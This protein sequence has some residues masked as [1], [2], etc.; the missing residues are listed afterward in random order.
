MPHHA[1]LVTFLVPRFARLYDSETLLCFA[2]QGLFTIFGL[3]G[4][5]FDPLRI[6]ISKK[7]L[8]KIV[9]IGPKYCKNA[10]KNFAKIFWTPV[11]PPYFR[12]LWVNR[13]SK[14][15]SEAALQVGNFM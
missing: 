15:K 1:V 6:K 2:Q 4:W 5:Q 10:K 12:K 9:F 13:W 8:S 14:L 3:L 7:F 11:G